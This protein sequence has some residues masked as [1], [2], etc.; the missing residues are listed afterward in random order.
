MGL[1]LVQGATLNLTYLEETAREVGLDELL[2]EAL[3]RAELER[4]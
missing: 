3:A 4:P 2:A 1:L